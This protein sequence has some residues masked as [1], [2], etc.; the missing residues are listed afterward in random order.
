MQAWSAICTRFAS[1]RALTAAEWEEAIAVLTAT[2]DITDER[3]Q[4]FILWSDSLGRVDAGRRDREHGFRPGATES[5]VQGPFYVA[6]LA[7]ARVR[8]EHRQEP[9]AGV[10]AS[11]HGRVLDVSG[12]PIAGAEVDVWQNGADM[13]YAVQRPEARGG[14]PP[15]A[16]P[17]PRR[18]HLRVRGGPSDAV[19][20]P[21]RRPRRPDARAHRSPPVAPRP[22]PHDR[23]RA[24]LQDLTTHVFDVN[25]QYLDSDAVFAV[26]PSLTRE[27]V[28]R[29][30]DDPERPAGVP[31]GEWVSLENDIVLAPGE[32][33]GA[34]VDPGR[35]A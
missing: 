27:F 10:P 4:E 3:R 9:D 31:E 2:G 29:S 28:E 8:R 21:P 20:D 19:P 15:R 34:V 6:G 13:L 24:R 35:T 1:R 30:P 33:G 18:R 25:S 16:L 14:P 17:D 11:V 32:D 23:A 22:H 26:K 7:V 5:T 12:E